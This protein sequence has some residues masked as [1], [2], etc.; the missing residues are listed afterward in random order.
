MLKICPAKR[1]SGFRTGAELPFHRSQYLYSGSSNQ[2][3]LLRMISLHNLRR[4]LLWIDIL[5]K[6]VGGG[7]MFQQY[8]R[9]VV[10]DEREVRVLN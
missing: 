3:K 10:R 7:G 8:F 4:Q 9:F 5:V 2:P 6:K 1:N